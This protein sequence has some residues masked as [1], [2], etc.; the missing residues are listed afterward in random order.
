MKKTFLYFS[1]LVLL[2]AAAACTKD[3]PVPVYTPEKNTWV[4]HKEAGGDTL[5]PATFVYYDT[6]NLIYGGIVGKGSVTVRFMAKPKSDGEYVLRQKADELDEISILMIDSVN[7]ISY[8]STDND[9]LA[10]KGEQF[11]KVLVNGSS[12]GVSF[13]ELYLKR[14]DNNEKVQ[15]WLNIN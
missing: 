10:L 6:A 4:I 12:I 13:N 9:G 5:G 14:T 8:Q 7:N 3:H 2:S 15:T 11:A 1:A